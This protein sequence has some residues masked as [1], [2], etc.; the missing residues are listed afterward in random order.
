MRS[1]YNQDLYEK[2]FPAYEPQSVNGHVS[3]LF[4]NHDISDARVMENGSF[5]HFDIGKMQDEAKSFADN[6]SGCGGPTVDP[7]D[8][9]ADFLRRV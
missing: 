7:R 9:V 5:K 3:D 8:L 1:M 4:F 6:L 2:A